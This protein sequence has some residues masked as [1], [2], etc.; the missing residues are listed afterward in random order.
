M[1]FDCESIHLYLIDF[2]WV[3]VWLLDGAMHWKAYLS[4]AYVSV[5][6]GGIGEDCFDG[7]HV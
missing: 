2:C 3:L 7:C 4:L 5:K 6:G 1:S